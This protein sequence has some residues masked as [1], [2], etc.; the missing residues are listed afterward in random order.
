MDKILIATKNK[1]KVKDFKTLFNK[2]GIEVISLLDLDEEISDVEETGTTFEENATL[3][4][5]AIAEIMQMPVLA[6]DSGLAIDALDGA[7]GVYSARYAGMEKNDQKNIEKVLNELKNISEQE[8][9]AQFVCALALADPNGDTVI[10]QGYC[11]GHI[12]LE[13][14]GD[15]GFG[16]D[17]IFKPEHYSYTMAQLTPEQKSAISHRGQALHKLADWLALD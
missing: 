3:K 15:Q 6:D 11:K 13:P 8:R 5:E 10:K 1:G 12:T 4:A 7:P 2:Q 16:Y 17:P 9:T 14:I